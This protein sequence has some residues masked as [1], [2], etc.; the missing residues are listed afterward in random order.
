MTINEP[1]KRDMISCPTCRHFWG[2]GWCVYELLEFMQNGATKA[3]VGIVNEV[4]CQRCRGIFRR[5]DVYN[6]FMA[7]IGRK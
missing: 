6:H 1:D 3:S 4:K 7:V 2:Y 5:I